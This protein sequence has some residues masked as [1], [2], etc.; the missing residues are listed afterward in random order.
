[1]ALAEP[2][3]QCTVRLMQQPEPGKLDGS[4]ARAAITCLA[5][6]LLAI[7]ITAAPRTAAKPEIAA[8]FPAIFK[9]LVKGLVHELARE[10]RAERLQIEQLILSFD[11]L[12]RCSCH[13]HLLRRLFDRGKLLAH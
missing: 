9:V 2:L 5:D 3:A 8:D 1:R 4:V 11:H 12:Q 7:S 13:M 6:A 10:C